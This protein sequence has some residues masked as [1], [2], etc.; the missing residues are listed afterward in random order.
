MFSSS[1]KNNFAFLENKQKNEEKKEEN[2]L[3][4]SK[5][6]EQKEILSKTFLEN[7]VNNNKNND[8]K[9]NVNYNKLNIIND[10]N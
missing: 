9:R 1:P 7:K 8:E 6:K 5:S 3:R 4:M 2:L 10:K